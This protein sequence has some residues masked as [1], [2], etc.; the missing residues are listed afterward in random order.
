[1]PGRVFALHGARPGTGKGLILRSV[2]FGSMW[3][4][5]FFGQGLHVVHQRVRKVGPFLLRHR[6]LGGG[7]GGEEGE[8]RFFFLTFWFLR[9]ALCIVGMLALLVF[10]FFVCRVWVTKVCLPSGEVN[11]NVTHR[12]ASG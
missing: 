7:W 11:I 9:G 3:L 10:S 2:G 5:F 4:P 1:M 12:D 8:G 6:E